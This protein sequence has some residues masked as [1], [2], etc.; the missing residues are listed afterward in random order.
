MAGYEAHIHHRMAKEVLLKD[1]EVLKSEI[2][3]RDW[4]G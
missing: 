3:V 1:I 4:S 2:S